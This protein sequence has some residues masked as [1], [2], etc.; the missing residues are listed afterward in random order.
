MSCFPSLLIFVLYAPEKPHTCTKTY[1]HYHFNI[2]HHTTLI[3]SIDLHAQPM[4]G[5]TVA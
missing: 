5:G 1:I 3:Q 2:Q 4:N